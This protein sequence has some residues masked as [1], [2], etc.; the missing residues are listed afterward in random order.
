MDALTGIVNSLYGMPAVRIV[1]FMDQHDPCN[2]E[3]IA[4]SCHIDI[5]RVRY[6]LG[7]LEKSGVLKQSRKHWVFDKNEAFDNTKA[8]LETILTK[9]PQQSACSSAGTFVC[10]ACHTPRSLSECF[11]TIMETGFAMCC[12]QEMVEQEHDDT[13]KSAIDELIAKLSRP[14]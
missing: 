2:E 11:Q 6:C 9:I 5:R 8:I 7:V 3:F 4:A 14:K 1:E 12:D 10:A 13:L